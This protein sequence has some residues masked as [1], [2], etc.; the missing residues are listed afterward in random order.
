M[1]PLSPETPN[2]VRRRSTRRHHQIA[3][4]INHQRRV[5]ARQQQNLPTTGPGPRSAN[6]L[7]GFAWS[8]ALLCPALPR[9]SRTSWIGSTTYTSLSTPPRLPGGQTCVSTFI[10]TLDR[11]IIWP[12][13]LPSLVSHPLPHRSLDIPQLFP[14]RTCSPNTTPLSPP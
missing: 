2:D 3:F 5:Q 10:P 1:S 8:F 9:A 13:K 7:S 12:P 4:F 6:H 11:S 14:D